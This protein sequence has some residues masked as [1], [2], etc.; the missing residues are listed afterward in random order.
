VRA[1]LPLSLLVPVCSAQAPASDV[2]VVGGLTPGD[3]TRGLEVDGRVRTYI[4]H[5]PPG[6]RAG[7]PTPVVVVFHGGGTSARAA[8]D[9]TALPQKADR[10]GFV[11]VFPN[12][13]GRLRSMR[14]FNAGNCCG[15]AFENDVDDVAFTRAV[16]DD[17]AGVVTVDPKRVFAT[18]ISN[19]GM[20]SY[21]VAAE[22]SDRIAAIASI[23]G[24]MGTESA[25]PA[26]PVPVMHFHGTD[27][28][29]VP[30]E[31]GPGIGV[32]KTDFYSVERSLWTWMELNGCPSKASSRREIDT[33]EDDTRVVIETFGPGREGAEVVL[34]TIEGGG[35]SWPG[36]AARLRGLG[37]STRDVS[38]NDLMWG[39]FTRHPMP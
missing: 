1:L 25:A 17:L 28:R 38:A 32:S 16:L 31:G 11:A 13:T 8:M 39:F 12:G 14:T 6:Y 4:V 29:H 35:H 15:Y 33:E 24:P 5:V 20:M 36:R 34:V 21:L 3:H 30:I 23:A 22:L 2:E 26:R 10:A 7:T 18:G 9:Y 19:G 27:D 37:R